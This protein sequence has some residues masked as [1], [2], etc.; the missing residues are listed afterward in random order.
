MTDGER[1]ISLKKP[2]PLRTA[3]PRYR[4]AKQTLQNQLFDNRNRFRIAF[5][6]PESGFGSKNIVKK[7]MK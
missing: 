7:A 5:H 6:L 1:Q 2:P 3:H 4:T